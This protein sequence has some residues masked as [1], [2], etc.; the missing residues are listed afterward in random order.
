VSAAAWSALAEAVIG[1][2]CATMVT[3]ILLGA[4][5]ALPWQV[6]ARKRGRR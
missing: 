2:A 1:I 6:K 3:L 4:L 5:E